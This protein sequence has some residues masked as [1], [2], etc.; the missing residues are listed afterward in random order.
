MGKAKSTNRMKASIWTETMKVEIDSSIAGCVI[1]SFGLIDNAALRE[2]VI[3]RIQEQHT[4]MVDREQ[5][6]KAVEK[7]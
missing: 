5:V 3:A 4:K 7:S 2:K 1:D 6:R